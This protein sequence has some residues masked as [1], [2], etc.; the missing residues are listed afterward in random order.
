M[1]PKK[2]PAGGGVLGNRPGSGGTLFRGPFSTSLK[3]RILTDRKDRTMT[4]RQIRD[5]ILHS[6]RSERNAE[7]K[8]AADRPGDL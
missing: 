7:T 4:C 1:A 2:D 6:M 5:R 8:T 3:K